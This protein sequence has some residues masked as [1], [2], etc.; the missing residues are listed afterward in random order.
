MSCHRTIISAIFWT[1]VCGFALQFKGACS[2]E[3]SGTVF[4]QNTQDPVTGATV[5]IQLY[6]DSSDPCDSCHLFE[7]GGASMNSADGTFKISD[8]PSGS[9]YLRAKVYTGNYKDQWLGG[10][11]GLNDCSATYIVTVMDN[12]VIGDQNIFLE[13]GSTITGNLYQ[14]DGVTLETSEAFYVE[15]QS[16][17][18]CSESSVNKRITSN[19]GTFY[20]EG[21]PAGQ[22]QLSAAPRSN[23]SSYL[24]VWWAQPRSVLNSRD[25]EV[26][27]L[28]EYEER[29]GM[30]FQLIKEATISGRIY[31]SDG[32]TP[33]TGIDVDFYYSE[34]QCGYYQQ[35]Y[36]G[37]M[38]ED[39][40]TYTI[41]ELHSGTYY[42]SA[43]PRDG[44][45]LKEWWA[46]SSSATECQGA[47]PIVVVA[48]ESVIDKDF[49]LDKGA[50]ISGTLFERDGITTIGGAD[51]RIE[52]FTG[53][54][55]DG[56]STDFIKSVKV[57]ADGTYIVQGVPGDTYFFKSSAYESNYM[58]EWWAQGSSTMDCS[59]AT[60]LPVASEEAVKEVDFQLNRGAIVTG[61]I[62]EEDGVT[63]IGS[64]YARVGVHSA[65]PC[66]FN[67]DFKIIEVNSDGSFVIDKLSPGSYHFSAW[68][69]NEN[70]I[71]EWWA[72]PMSAIDCSTASPFSVALDQI[73]AGV[74]FQL[75][76][77][78]TIS[79]TVYESDGLRPFEI[80]TGFVVIAVSG[81]PCNKN[82][83]MGS[84]DIDQTDGSYQITGLNPGSYY[85]QTTPPDKYYLKEWWTPDGSDNDCFDAVPVVV[86][87]QEESREK[88]FQLNRGATISGTAYSWDGSPLPEGIG[89]LRV[90][91]SKGH[92]NIHSQVISE[93]S[94]DV[95]TNTYTLD[96]LPKGTY[97][98]KLDGIAPYEYWAAP[99][100]SSD[101]R[102]AEWTTIAAEQDVTEKNFYLDIGR[103]S[104]SGQV[105][106]GDGQ[107]PVTRGYA[108]LYEKNTECIYNRGI[109]SI[110]WDSPT[111][112]Y[113][114]DSIPP[115][116]FA[117]KIAPLELDKFIEEWWVA[118]ESSPDCNDASKIEINGEE[119][120]ENIDFRLDVSSS[121]AGT[122]F[123]T[124][125]ISPLETWMGGEVYAYQ[126]AHPCDLDYNK[127]TL[128][129]I[130][131]SVEEDGSY[132]VE[133]L[134]DGQYYLKA[135]ASYLY[136]EDDPEVAQ[137]A[138]Y[139]AEYWTHEGSVTD[140]NQAALLSVGPEQQISDIDF[141]IE[142]GARISGSVTESDP[143]S[144]LD[145]F[146]VDI[147]FGD[148]CDN[149]RRMGR[150]GSGSS[151]SETFT[152]DRLPPGSYYLLI[153]GDGGRFRQIPPVSNV[154]QW[155]SFNGVTSDCSAASSISVAAEEVVSGVHVILKP[156][157]SVS[158]LIY[159]GDG[160]TP[161][162]GE[163]MRVLVYPSSQ[164]GLYDYLF[165]LEERSIGHGS[166]DLATGKYEIRGLSAGRYYLLA[167]PEFKGSYED[168]WWTSGFGT[169]NCTDAVPIEVGSMDSVTNIDFNLSHVGSLAGDV[170]RDKEVKLD[171]A[172]SVLR[173][174]VGFGDRQVVSVAGDVDNN[175]RI[176][177]S[178]VI[179][180]LQRIAN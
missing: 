90:T 68:V 157:S 62:F 22:Y 160:I 126:A 71:K 47:E 41:P 64:E 20:L 137:L 150:W 139:A 167:W 92:P 60:Q 179:Y 125:G 153:R 66:D 65:D 121:I 24:E 110:K 8:V 123:H 76:T 107:T 105:L 156:L 37:R 115:G 9:Y 163:E 81:D 113:H 45:Y 63:R 84:G 177:S 148:P 42:L 85:L 159:K 106:A 142:K 129:S 31:Q 133:G 58:D 57:N 119:S 174:L 5:Y 16:V 61:T 169:I 96:G 80:K 176:D 136:T 29:T 173:T 35:L 33:L 97:F 140:C 54:P 14:N 117:L 145:S 151:L 51:I 15:L 88:D 146:T 171:D 25:A 155:W 152:L 79:G 165:Q 49:Q 2:A 122:I 19:D 67:D 10:S 1:V 55:C 131:D 83:S 13:T 46:Q 141:Q 82:E 74:D 147:F 59:V 73:Y 50:T 180:I 87:A 120:V 127:E 164:C 102:K 36:R 6:T 162:Q 72:Y 100:S 108:Y 172:I 168:T 128:V 70:Y 132:S 149:P 27:L 143:E 40:G 34:D 144:P 18:S 77:G 170:N 12:E 130:V 109:K 7:H 38:D 101:F 69:G 112:H 17:D 135:S 26:F 52:V 23:Y 53:N 98:L 178:D 99:Q 158:G 56:N 3:I 93:A 4:S 39:T 43:I 118:P 103:A 161:L 95:L 175:H 104:I 124:D 30:D 134:P 94:I 21:L 138:N 154:D 48:E 86:Q 44:N 11:G 91:A 114:I 89:Q 78:A 166:V 32:V 111:G 75:D 116:S 28:R